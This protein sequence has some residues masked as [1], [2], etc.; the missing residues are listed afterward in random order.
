MSDYQSSS[1]ALCYL[2]DLA[3]ND[4][5][6]FVKATRR[7][8]DQKNIDIFALFRGVELEFE[9]PTSLSPGRHETFFD[10]IYTLE[11]LVC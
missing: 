8:A 9:L 10:L 4:R 5:S 3:G 7:D 6:Y 1:G 2:D 11:T